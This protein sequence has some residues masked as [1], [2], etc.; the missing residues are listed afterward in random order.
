VGGGG[1]VLVCVVRVKR[2]GEERESWRVES[3]VK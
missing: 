2:E 3:R 1:S